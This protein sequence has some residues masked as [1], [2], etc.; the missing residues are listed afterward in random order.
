MTTTFEKILNKI[1]FALFF[2]IVGM[3]LV[4]FDV[5]APTEPVMPEELRKLDAVVVDGLSQDPL[6]ESITK[7]TIDSLWKFN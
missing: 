6:M 7:F 3:L 2:M 4:L 5:K 1:M